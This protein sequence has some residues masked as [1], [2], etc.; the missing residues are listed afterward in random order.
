MDGGVQRIAVARQSWGWGSS[1]HPHSIRC[2]RK[3]RPVSLMTPPLPLPLPQ[4]NSAASHRIQT[5]GST[6]AVA[7]D[8]VLPRDPAAR[9]AKRNRSEQQQQDP[10]AEAAAADDGGAAAAAA[11]DEE[12][13]GAGAADEEAGGIEVHVVTEEEAA[14][15]TYS[16]ADVV[17]PMPGSETQMPRHAIAD[18]YRQLAEA[19]GLSLDASAHGTQEFSITSLAGAYRHVMYRP[20]DLEVRPGSTAAAAMWLHRGAAACVCTGFHLSNSAA[21]PL[22][23]L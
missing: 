23:C 4:W 20:T 10:G 9:A 15:G 8:L 17:L 5:Y 22:P 3:Q 11:A 6:G 16:M 1:Q 21:P 2:G 19:D 13:E 14:A 7:G 12:G 18:V